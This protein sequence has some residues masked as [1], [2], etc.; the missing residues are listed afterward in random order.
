MDKNTYIYIDESGDLTPINNGG[1]T[2]FMIGCIITDDAIT[3]NTKIN[4]LKN[5]ILNGAYYFGRNRENFIKEGFHASTN[6]PDIY[7]KFVS[8]LNTLNFR[9]YFVLIDKNKPKFD[10]MLRREENVYY[11]ILKKLIKDRLLKLKDENIHIVLEQST[12]KKTIENKAVSLVIEEIN[13]TFI[14]DGLIS[15][16]INIT[17]KIQG[18]NED[19]G[20]DVIDYINHI[21]YTAKVGD[22]DGK[23]YPGHI[24][25][26]R[27]IEPK[28][29]LISDLINNRYFEGR[30]EKLSLLDFLN[31]V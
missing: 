19:M 31:Y 7:G 6:H 29:A 25:N 22:K 18:K 17:Y 4:E 1:K 8:I 15:K 28:I 13:K 5:E 20:V 16:P 24:E 30:K 2:I 23:K 21:I 11:F 12:T 14:E 10:E 3:L 26:L 9:S 27:L